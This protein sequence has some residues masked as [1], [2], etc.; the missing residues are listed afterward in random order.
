MLSYLFEDYHLSVFQKN[1]SPT[2]NQIMYRGYLEPIAL[3]FF[4]FF[5]PLDIILA[6]SI[7]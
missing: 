4:P 2:C 6:V 5:F 1:G 3:L 7:F